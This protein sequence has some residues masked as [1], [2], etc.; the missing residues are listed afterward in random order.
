MQSEFIVM[1][2]IFNTAALD[3]FC[4][5]S[6]IYILF[7]HKANIYY[8]TDPVTVKNGGSVIDNL[9]DYKSKDCKIDPP[10]LQSL[11][12]D[13]KQALSMMPRPQAYKTFSCSTQ[14]S[15][16]FFL[17]LNVKRPTIVGIF[18]IYEWEK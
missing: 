11:G 1:H 15:M 3:F 6:I 13:F 10:T 2:M 5:H 18:N 12:W 9:Q 4:P 7:L 8:Y 16:K 17:L 14:L